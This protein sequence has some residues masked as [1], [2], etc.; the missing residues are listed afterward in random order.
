MADNN[1]KIT[2][3]RTSSARITIDMTTDQIIDL[4]IGMIIE[5]IVEMIIEVRAEAITEMMDSSARTTIL[6]SVQI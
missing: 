4:T 2:A 3:G 5:T 1:V 6:S